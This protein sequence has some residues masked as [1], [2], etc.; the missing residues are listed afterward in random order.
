MWGGLGRADPRLQRSA[1]STRWSRC[2]HGDASASRPPRSSSAST[3]TSTDWREFVRRDDLDLVSVCTPVDLHA[4][5]TI[6]AVEA[7]KHVL[8]EKPV[9]LD[10][11]KRLACPRRRGGGRRARGALREPVRPGA[12]RVPRRRSPAGALGDPYFA[13]SHTSA[14]Y[15]HPR[16]ASSRSGC[17]ASAKAA[18]TSWVCR[19]TTS[20]SCATCLVSPS[21]SAPTCAAPSRSDPTRRHDPSRSTPTTP[22]S[23]CCA[24]TRG[25]PHDQLL[26]RRVRRE[27]TVSSSC[28]G[29]EGRIVVEGGVQEGGNAVRLHRVGDERAR[30]P[31]A[32]RA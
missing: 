13:R 24:C 18:D 31:G 14:D 11:P 32:E 20:T 19:R 8:C 28:A 9:A 17:T 21:R 7:G 30:D 10:A 4:E 22:R 5:Q 16:A 27:R 2:A 12:A 29:S 15:W 3:E 26:G 25:R 6:A 1:R 23:S